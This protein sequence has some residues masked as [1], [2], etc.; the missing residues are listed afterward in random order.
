MI[1]PDDPVYLYFQR[2]NYE[3]LF[4]I[5]R[6]TDKYKE[7]AHAIFLHNKESIIP[8]L[9]Q[10]KDLYSSILDDPLLKH[11]AN[12]LKRNETLIDVQEDLSN[13][14]NIQ[15]VGLSLDQT[16][17]K[18]LSNKQEKKIKTILKKFKVND[19]KYY[20]IACRTLIR[21]KRFEDLYEFAT[22]KKSPIGYLPFYKYLKK[23]RKPKESARYIPMITE[24]SYKDKIKTLYEVKGYYELAQMF[25]K[26]KN[27]LALKDLYQQV[28]PNE[29]QLRSFITETIS[30]M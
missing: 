4:D 17:E 14:L 1:L 24:M 18:L 28:P 12:F 7:L 22:Q 25:T 15:F 26:E 16:I 29:P 30:K 5:F 19:K 11:D 6:Q 10:I 2:N 21:E 9:P 3:F 23:A 27:I 20:H 8:F 13:T